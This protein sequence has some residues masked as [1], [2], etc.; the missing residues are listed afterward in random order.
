MPKAAFRTAYCNSYEQTELESRIRGLK[1]LLGCYPNS[2]EVLS[3]LGKALYE[4]HNSVEAANYFEKLIVI[5]EEKR[6]QL[7]EILDEETIGGEDTNQYDVSYLKRLQATTHLDLAYAFYDMN[8][9]EEAK[10]NLRAFEELADKPHTND[11]KDA[12]DL[13]E[14]ID[15]IGCVGYSAESGTAPE[16]REED[17]EPRKIFLLVVQPEN[18]APPYRHA[19]PP[20]T[21]RRGR[22]ACRERS[23]GLTDS[24]LA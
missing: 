3:K 20:H 1:T 6:K 8:E 14:D 21:T 22:R 2:L 18:T 4:N 24:T 13:R 17:T 16:T 9:I 10:Q 19:R 11:I 23:D 12:G 5:I 15:F 7:L